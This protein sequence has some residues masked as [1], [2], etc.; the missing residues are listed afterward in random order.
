MS[1][2]GKLLGIATRTARKAPMNEVFAARITRER[3]VDNDAR[4]KAGRR[5]VTVITRSGWEAACADLG[6]E[7][8]P[9]TTRRANLLV[10][11]VDLKGKIGYNLRVGEAVLT[12]N[13]ETRP[14]EVM[15]QA[16]MGLMTALK[17]EWRGGVICRVT[18]SGDIAVGCEVVLSRNVIKQ[19]AWLSYNRVRPLWKKGRGILTRIA[20][21]M[22]W[23]KKVSRY[24]RESGY[25][26]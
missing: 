3:G 22:G 13:G 8:L 16:R 20:Q 17:P 24:E 21:R 19:A 23:T 12:I 6:G 25:H 5:Q 7:Q 14:C 4:G 26:S 11:G 9:W 2:K 18:R 15:N 10:D 1:K